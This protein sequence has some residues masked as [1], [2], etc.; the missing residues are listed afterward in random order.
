M[1]IS[2]FPKSQIESEETQQSLSAL[3]SVIN[4]K[5]AR[6]LHYRPRRLLSRDN[7]SALLEKREKL[8]LPGHWSLGSSGFERLENCTLYLNN[9]A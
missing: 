7:L 3:G 6:G 2:E 9:S 5:D 4:I 8:L 1:V